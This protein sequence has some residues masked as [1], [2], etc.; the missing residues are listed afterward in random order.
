MFKNR[1]ITRKL[2]AVILL[3]SGA[4]L[5]LACG[6]FLVYE[7]VT[8]RQSMVRNLTTLAKAIAANS[9]A[10][11]AFQNTED[12]QRVLSAVAADPHVVAAAA[13]DRNGILFA[14]Y[15]NPAVAQDPVPVLERPGPDGYRFDRA[16]LALYEPITIENRRLGTLYLR[17]D[18]GAMYQRL[19]LYGAMVLGVVAAASLL[20]FVL[21]TRLQRYITN[22]VLTL[23]RTAK[24]VSDQQDYSARAERF[25][26]DE[27]GQLTDAFNVMLERV[28]DRDHALRAQGEALRA[29]EE[30]T[31][32]IVDT[33]L[34]AVITMDTAGVIT[35]WNP[36]AERTFGWTRPEAMGRI[37]EETIVPEH[38]RDS[39][40]RGLER[41]RDTGEGPVL[42]RRLEL[43]ALHRDGR[44]FP[45]ELA[46]TP[47]RVGETVSFSAFVRDITE[48]Q[49]TERALVESQEHY[50]A[51]AESLP[52]LVWTCR[53]NGYCDFLSRQWVEYTGRPAAEQLGYGWAEQ[54]HPDDRARAETEW[55]AATV[56]GDTFD[57]E[58][59]IRRA[60]GTYRWFKTRAVPL[61]DASGAIAKWFGSNTDFDDFKRSEERLRSQLE[62]LNLLDRLTRAISERQDLQSILQV[63][64]RSL[65][66]QLPLDF[67]CIALYDRTDESIV[68]TRVG[69]KSEALALE[70][71]MSEKTRVPIDQNGLSR[72][73]RG[74][75]IHEP[76]LAQVASAFPQRL[77][78]GGLR[79]LVAAPL[80]VESKVFGVLLAARRDS[81]GFTSAEC[82][83]LRQLSEHVALASHQAEL[84]SA[85]QR[86]YDDL[87]Q[88]QHA[89]MQQE[90]LKALG[91]MASGIAHDINNAISPVALYT[92]SLLETE[93]QLSMQA[94]G[95]LSTIQRAIEDVAQTVARMREFYRER[96]PQLTLA[97]VQV[98]RLVQEV[99]NLTRARWSDMPQQRGVVI[100]L[101]TELAPD[102]PTVLGVE[103]EL[104]EALINLIFNAVDAMPDGG[105][106]T[107]RTHSVRRGAAQPGMLPHPGVHIE[108]TDS[109]IG[110]NAE[111]RRRCMEPFFTTKGERGTGLGLA[112]VYGT[113][114]RHGA[115]IEVDSAP[116]QGTT[117][118]LVFAFPSADSALPPIESR[119]DSPRSS[120]LRILVVDDDPLLLKSLRD[121][122]EGDGHVVHTANGG[123]A[124]IDTF[125]SAHRDGTPF[126]LVIT[127]LGMPYVDGRQVANRIK[128]AASTMPVILLTGWGQRLLDDGDIPAHVDR[129]LS[130][131]P[132]LSELRVA[133]S[134]LTSAPRS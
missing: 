34:D 129:V 20:A 14:S 102:D 118:Q 5:T 107:I 24:A 73:V 6:T 8:F 39:H 80:A 32:L 91:Q 43:S 49:R 44:E 96:E 60:D 116:G 119:P 25:D 94:R 13:Y 23:A 70:L 52:H 53:P 109:G 67:C 36:Q 9:T 113:V 7:L 51:L 87:R 128:Q 30:R 62:R 72:C 4:V 66:D 65:E 55:G 63:V 2:L 92:E 74:Q 112:M 40:R 33:A 27:L 85:L 47:V 126:N 84:Y 130:K 19:A 69:V 50:R 56:R 76:D 78:R 89:V 71:A 38:H 48:R 121:V 61:R 86:A 90:R 132:R 64:I 104:R 82:E 21:A 110:M 79:S 16:S 81:P 115:D 58:F 10:A 11:L 75:L 46:I 26:D 103:S 95:Y 134:D 83:F 37:L 127:D 31:R 1:P 131:P 22:P 59:R 98:N 120:R 101:S 29:N 99:V 111:T 42:N 18:L 17:S 54:L 35:G 93:P 68:I 108:V 123:Q 45:I 57:I 3:T 28:Q 15:A 114:Q 77:A 117:F 88:T 97:S 125:L 100:Q 122:L 133:L 12:A 41:F 124:G 105:T 106:L